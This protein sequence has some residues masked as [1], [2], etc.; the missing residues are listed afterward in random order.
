MRNL[1]TYTSMAAL[2]ILTMGQVHAA[3]GGGGYKAPVKTVE[4]T[5]VQRET[6]RVVAV[7]AAVGASI[8]STRFDSVRGMLELSK[9]QSKDISN[10]KSEINNENKKLVKAQSKAQSKLDDCD[11]DCEDAKRALI[12]ST[13]ALNQYNANAEFDLRLR[14]ILRP[15]QAATYFRS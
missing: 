6:P 15:T 12:R 11:G 14:T 7:N 4:A 13:N 9:N 1:L 5:Q 2:A 8:D 10:A 3:C